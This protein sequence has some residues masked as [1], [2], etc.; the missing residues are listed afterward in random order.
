[1]V[2]AAVVPGRR[3][4]SR[5]C[6]RA[7]STCRGRSRSRCSAILWIGLALAHAVCCASLPHG[8]GLL[9]DVLMATF[10]GDTGAYFGGRMY[11]AHAARAADLAEQDGRG[12]DRRHVV[13]GTLAFWFAGLY[14]DWLT[15]P[16][17]S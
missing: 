16:T 8:D 1:M 15:G 7:A 12:A 17:R 10:L 5:C 14:Q 11:G 6:G 2:L 9:I 4:S 3:S 13:G